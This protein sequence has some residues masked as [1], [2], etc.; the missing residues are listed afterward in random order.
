VRNAAP[1]LTI[2]PA[3][4]SAPDVLNA[5][6]VRS[7]P[8]GL[9]YAGALGII[10]IADTRAAPVAAAFLLAVAI[11]N[12]NYLLNRNKPASP[13]VGGISGFGPGGVA[14]GG[15]NPSTSP[16]SGGGGSW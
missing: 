4:M 7:V 10:A 15:G 2:A 13:G 12:A 5:S 16:G 11:Y 6:T 14:G 3:T 9:Y 8:I 1:T